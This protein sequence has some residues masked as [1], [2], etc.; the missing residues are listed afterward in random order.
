MENILNKLNDLEIRV[1]ELKSVNYQNGKDEYRSITQL[2]ETCLRHYLSKKPSQTL[3]PN[4][5]N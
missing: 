4:Q 1:Q 3:T 5:S 2:L